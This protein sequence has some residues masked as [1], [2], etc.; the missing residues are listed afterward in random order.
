MLI[1]FILIFFL[2]S[3]LVRVLASVFRTRQHLFYGYNRPHGF[4]G[5]H[6]CSRHHRFGRGLLSI[7]ALVALER[8]FTHRF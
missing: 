4:G 5:H 7:L 3:A 6:L 2:I 8:L 1:A